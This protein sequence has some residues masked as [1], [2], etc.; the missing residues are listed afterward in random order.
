MFLRDAVSSK[1]N[2]LYNL[3]TPI[4]F[5]PQVHNIKKKCRYIYVILAVLARQ[6]LQQSC[7]Y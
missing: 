6:P 1:Y 2:D 5:D 7:V 3:L 4:L